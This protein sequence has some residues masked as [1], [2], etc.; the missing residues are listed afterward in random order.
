MSIISLTFIAFVILL[1]IVYF[2]LPY[3]FQWLILLVASFAFYIM[4]GWRSLLYIL[5]T[6]LTQYFLAIALDNKNMEMEKEVLG[7]GNIGGKEKKVI[8]EKYALVKKKY[9]VLSVLLNI[10]LLCYFKYLNF[11]IDNLNILLGRTESSAL[12]RIDILVPLG[13]SFYTLKSIGYV[14]DVYRGRNRA[15]R[16]FFKLA[17]FISY[18]PAIVQGPIDRYGDLAAQLYGKHH[19]DYR[20]V[21]FGIQRM[22]WGYIKKL[23]IADRAA[24]IVN[25][26]LLNYEEKGYAGFVIFIAMCLYAFQIY[27]DFSGGM[28]IVCGVSEILGISLTENFR[29]PFLG[30]SIAEYWQ[31]W[32]IT[33][34]AWMRTYVFYPLSLSPAFSKLGKACRKRFGDSVGKVIAPSLASFIVF[35]LIGIW[36]GAEWKYVIYGVYQAIFV[37]TGTLFEGLYDTVRLRLNIDQSAGTF[38]VFQILRTFFIV[39]MGRYISNAKSVSDIFGLLKATFTHYNPWIFFNGTLYNLGLNQR[40][41]WF[42]IYAIIFLIIIDVVQERGVRIRQWIAERNIILRWTIYYLAIFTLIIFGM[43]GPGFDVNNFIYQGF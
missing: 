9:V 32:H 8:K 35:L 22:L 31:R 25:E 16:N 26:V 28:D 37:S 21:M 27:A 10:G 29:R 39:T 12:H 36:H 42:L 15:E 3:K 6:I 1:T 24:I 40:N 18:F 34:G 13:I 11:V 5:V 7:G 2:L 38:K 23:V 41:F 4:N 33:L 43:Y 17:L 19:F 30:R 14:I 20:R